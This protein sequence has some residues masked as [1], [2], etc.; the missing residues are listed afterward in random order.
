MKKVICS[1]HFEPH[2]ISTE[3]DKVLLKPG[4]VSR[5]GTVVPP[6]TYVTVGRGKTKLHPDAVPTIFPTEYPS[7][8]KKTV[9]KRKGPPQRHEV[10]AKNRRHGSSSKDTTTDIDTV[11]QSN[12]VLVP[13]EHAETEIPIPDVTPA[14]V[15]QP[16]TEAWSLKSKLEMPSSEWNYYIFGQEQKVTVVHLTPELEKDKIVILKKNKPPK[17]LLHGIENNLGHTKQLQTVQ[18]VNKLIKKVECLKL[19]QGTGKITHPRSAV[20]E[21]VTKNRMRRCQFCRKERD[22]LRKEQERQKVKEKRKQL[23]KKKKAQQAKSL[24]RTVSRLKLR[25]NEF[26]I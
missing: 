25:V 21:G 23:K 6:G 19:C 5:D 4:L 7:Y 15:Q 1:K 22:R 24:K 13:V 11:H 20:C 9:K 8:M 26:G 10:P 16:V 14:V 2:F 3:Y 17:I 12:E 18:E